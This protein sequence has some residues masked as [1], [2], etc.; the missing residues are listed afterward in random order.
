MKD[1][2]TFHDL[3]HRLAD[4]VGE[5]KVAPDWKAIGD[6]LAHRRTDVATRYACRP[7][8]RFRRG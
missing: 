5:G 2:Y 6:L 4:T 8:D 1:V 7:S 3:R